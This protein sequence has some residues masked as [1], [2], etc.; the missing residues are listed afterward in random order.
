[1][2][3]DIIHYLKKISKTITKSVMDIIEKSKDSFT[4]LVFETYKAYKGK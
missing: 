3:I 1:M 2:K 4:E